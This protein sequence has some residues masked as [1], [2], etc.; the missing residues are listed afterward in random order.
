[1]LNEAGNVEPCIAGASEAFARY[2]L[3]ADIQVVDD[4]S[5]DATARELAEI[6]PRFPQVFVETHPKN[7]GFGIARRTGIQA[8]LRRGGYEFVMFMDAD[9]TMD[10]KYCVGFH[11][12]IRDGYDFV[13]GSR[14]IEGGGME[15]VPFR[16]A[17]VSFIGGTIFRVA[18]R[19][20]IRD[21]TQGFRAIRSSIAS[22]LELTEPGF[23]VIM[24][25]I[26]QARRYT[27]KFAEV[28]FVLTV[29]TIGVSK[30]NYNLAVFRRYLK[31]AMLALFTR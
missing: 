11:D 31:Y 29:R 18:F 16:R 22:K 14:F 30:F 4:G 10:P 20:G 21:Y 26:Y 3:Q 13:I 5:T 27:R 9:L 2:G 28:P 23:P 1:M 25:E 17:I 6:R 19:L 7:M 12:K 15:K 24:Q 8:A